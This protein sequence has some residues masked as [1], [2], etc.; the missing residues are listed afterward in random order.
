MRSPPVAFLR[1]RLV[2]LYLLSVSAV[3]GVGLGLAPVS[4]RHPLWIVLPPIVL[5]AATLGGAALMDR[6]FSVVD[7]AGRGRLQLLAWVIYGFVLVMVLA[8]LLTGERGQ[9]AVRTGAGAMRLAQA[10]FLLFAGLGRGYLGAITNAFAL[11]C[12]ATLG[13]G[14]VATAAL[15]AHAGLLAFF[16][17]ADHHARLFTDYPVDVPPRSGGVLLRAAA[18]GGA[19]S[20]AIALFSL[21]V[22]FEPYAPLVSPRGGAAHGL[23]R[24]QVWELFGYLVG[25][26]VLAGAGLWLALRL[27]S[28]RGGESGPA[29]AARVAARRVAEPVAAAP[30]LGDAADPQGWRA[31]IVKAY[32]RLTGQLARLGVRRTPAQTPREFAQ[33]LAPAAAAESLT[34]LF[35][36][37]RYGDAEPG[38]SEFHAASAAVAQILD[39]FRGQK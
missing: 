14:A 6:L 16:L 15:S 4:S 23:P 28:G 38:E 35:V 18:V 33:A 7:R 31:R 39:H 8:G 24:E 19:L 2:A 17:V 26:T 37:A 25:V 5:A 32:V 13:G 1:A 34:D 36:R 11:T 20:G 10:G 30:P 12:V 27:G 29:P 22:P 3:D 9:G 21:G